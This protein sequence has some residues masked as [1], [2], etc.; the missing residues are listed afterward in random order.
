MAFLQLQEKD[1]GF[2]TIHLPPIL[3]LMKNLELHLMVYI[4]IFSKVF[5]LP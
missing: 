5:S 2:F 4:F 1:S 3:S